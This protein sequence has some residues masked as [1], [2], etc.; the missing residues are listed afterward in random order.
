MNDTG[1]PESVR[2]VC[3]IRP[4]SE[5]DDMYDRESI[6]GMI[7]D[8]NESAIRVNK[9]EYQFDMTLSPYIGQQETY[10]KVAKELVES[11]IQGYNGTIFAYGQ[12]GSGKTYTMNGI[13]KNPENVG[14]IPRIGGRI[15]E[16]M[17][18][19]RKKA[20]DEGG[21]PPEQHVKI[22]YYEIYLED[23]YDL[24]DPGKGRL[25]M[26]T[27]NN[28][29][30]MVNGLSEIYINTEE[31]LMAAVERGSKRQHITATQ[32]NERSSR[33]HSILIIKMSQQDPIEHRTLNGMLTLVDLAGSE[34]VK[35]SGV[36]GINLNETRNINT[37][38]LVLSKVITALNN[39]THVPYRE[40]K[41]T[42]ILQES[43]GGNTKTTI[44]LCCSPLKQDVHE[45]R[46]TLEFGCRAKRIKNHVM[47]NESMSV[48]DWEQKY[49]GQID[50]LQSLK[51]K[52]TELEARCREVGNEKLI[53]E[54]EG[55]KNQLK[56]QE[57]LVEAMQA[58][59]ENHV[60]ELKEYKR[61]VGE[62][63]I[64]GSRHNDRKKKLAGVV[65][66]VLKESL[67]ETKTAH[68]VEVE[69]LRKKISERD[70]KIEEL[71]TIEVENLR[72]EISEKDRKIEELATG[73]WRAKLEVDKLR[74]EL[75]QK[76]NEKSQQTKGE[77]EKKPTR[78][79]TPLDRTEL[80]N[81]RKTVEQERKKLGTQLN[82][83]LS[84]SSQE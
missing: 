2:T 73:E 49:N 61:V 48:E 11:C 53:E 82:K 17:N 29:K 15:F 10:N 34:N 24:L 66:D 39:D 46:S 30:P 6:E 57:K 36:E 64:K 51:S 3:K 70:K 79:R 33:S 12:T 40:S 44:I 14:I 8:K 42:R 45:T 20:E 68:Q 54:N 58:E 78:K 72:E 21:P 16:Y 50:E 83:M 69:K 56:Q 71:A 25:G 38:L 55:L 80:L 31:E 77:R 4:R 75:E 22:S 84:R 62:Y 1:S 60:K 67:N 13:G 37:S 18:N 9:T 35:R 74:K 28:G 19:I 41:L 23:F 43:L 5:D 76:T 26:T 47:L 63:E 81:L 59:L 7:S 65:G 52:V 32:M 27:S